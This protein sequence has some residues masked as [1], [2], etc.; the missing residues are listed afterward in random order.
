MPVPAPPPGLPAWRTT[1]PWILGAGA[2]TAAGV[3][4]WQHLGWRSNQA[5]F[6]K[7]DMCGKDLP[8][9]GGGR[10]PDL[11]NTLTSRRTGAYVS[12]G[13][14]GAL[15]VGAAVMVLWNASAEKEVAIDAGGGRFAVSVRGR[16]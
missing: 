3:G 2:V 15:G 8:E 6:E 9:K 13:V 7:I 12:Y 1:L 14:A 5:E 11:Y 16:F 10:C 4:V